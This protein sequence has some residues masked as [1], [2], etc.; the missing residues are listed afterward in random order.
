VG[1]GIRRFCTL[2][3]LRGLYEIVT[4]TGVVVNARSHQG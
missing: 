4:S 1:P 3:S 2:V